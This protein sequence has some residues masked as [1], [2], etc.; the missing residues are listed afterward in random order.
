M[1][2]SKEASVLIVAAVVV[3]LVLYSRVVKRNGACMVN[4]LSH[5]CSFLDISY[6]D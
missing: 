4:K 5:W 1:G 3:V 6:I 2:G